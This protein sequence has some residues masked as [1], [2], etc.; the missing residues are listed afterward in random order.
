MQHQPVLA[1]VVSAAH[2]VR[3]QERCQSGLHIRQP[4]ATLWQ[5]NKKVLIF[6]ALWK[7]SLFSRT[8]QLVS[9]MLLCAL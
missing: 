2:A 9:A 7:P 1:S 4:T 3:G 6:D 8:A 5:Q